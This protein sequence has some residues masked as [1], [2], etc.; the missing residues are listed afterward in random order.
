[1]TSET[2]DRFAELEGRLDALSAE[3]TA[4]RSENARLRAAGTPAPTPHDATAPARGISRRGLIAA[5]AGAA[6][7]A[8]IGRV[9]PAAAATNDP[10]LAGRINTAT[11]TTLIANTGGTGS[12]ISIQ[13][14]SPTFGDAGVYGFAS[15]TTGGPVGVWGRADAPG[16]YG[17]VGEA[18]STAAAGS[19][20][21][22][23]GITAAGS[24]T[25]VVG[26]ASAISGVTTGVRGVCSSPSG[27]AFFGDGRM[28][29]TGRVFLGSPSSAPADGDLSNGS[30]SIYLDE[31]AN[32]LKI[33]ARYSNGTLKT[34]SVNLA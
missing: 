25:G 18:K 32:K 28:K 12:G 24:G 20:T 27:W 1:M 9:S 29:V 3:V 4:L 22:V 34:A 17:V 19:A 26:I 2:T 16:G 30:V 15:A 8:A 11:A 6:G 23:R 10:V 5:A 7:A 13:G 14:T 31:S 33:R 21:G